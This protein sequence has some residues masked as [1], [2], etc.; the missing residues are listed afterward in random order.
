MSPI[1]LAAGPV[2]TI[3]SEVIVSRTS[4]MIV[5]PSRTG[6]FFQIGRPSGASQT[7][8]DA[9]MNAAM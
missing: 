8:L 9:S 7:L 2:K 3:A 1:S 5:V 4:R 6:S